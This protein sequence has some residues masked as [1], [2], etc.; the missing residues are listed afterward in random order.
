MQPLTELPGL[1]AVAKQAFISMDRVQE[2][3]EYP[4]SVRPSG[5]LRMDALETLELLDVSFSYREGEHM[6]RTVSFK[7]RA[8]EWVAL[9][10]EVGSGK[11]TI[12]KLAAGILSPTSGSVAVNGVDLAGVSLEW[13]RELVGYVPQEG[14]LFSATVGDNIRIGREMDDRT[15]I[16]AL[17]IAQMG[18]DDRLPE[19]LDT[20]L[21]HRGSLVSG[22]QRQRL[23]LARAL[24]GSPR[25][26]LLDDC[27]AS[28]DAETERRF[29]EHMPRGSDGAVLMVSH[30]LATV[31]RADR[32]VFLRNGAIADEGSHGRLLETN[33]EYRRVLLGPAS[34]PGGCGD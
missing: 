34:V 30:R 11:T 20:R 31:E 6:L 3:D 10:G 23:A 12:L 28:L 4:A 13:Y 22:G 9:V 32:V 8:G 1:P 24:A 14:G 17:D 16:R 18:T 7:V 33:D 27:T 25:L 19:G 15:V 2:I 29:W 5:G 26:L 21:G